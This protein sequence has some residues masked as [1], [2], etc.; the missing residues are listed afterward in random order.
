MFWTMF[1]LFIR[2]VTAFWQLTC[3]QFHT[4]FSLFYFGVGGIR[5]KPS[6]PPTPSLDGGARRVRQFCQTLSQNFPKQVPGG[7]A[8]C[9]RPSALGPPSC[10]IG[11]PFAPKSQIFAKYCQIFADRKCIK[12]RIPQ[13]SAK[14]LK[15]RTPDRPNIDLFMIFGIHLG[16]DF[17]EILDFVIIFENH[18]N[19]YIQSI[20]EGSALPEFHI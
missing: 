17:H 12:N 6:N 16:I 3:L 5:R 9:R 11:L 7:S 13:N 19:A 10:A 20:W 2:F 14:N 4:A 18:P 15:S 8:S 1:R